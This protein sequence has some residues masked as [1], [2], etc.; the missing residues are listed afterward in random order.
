MLEGPESVETQI[1]DHHGLIAATCEDL[2]LAERID[3]RLS[4]CGWKTA[5][6]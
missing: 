2:R 5:T 6:V 1:L 4:G 3:K